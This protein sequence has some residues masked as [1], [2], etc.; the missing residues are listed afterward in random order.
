MLQQVTCPTIYIKAT[1]NYAADGT[2]LAANTE[3]DAAMVISC[4][5]N[6]AKAEMHPIKSG[7]DVH[8]EKPKVFIQTI[9]DCAD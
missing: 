3:E 1:T 8:Y 6:A 7:H 2:L 5:Q 4:L 9:E